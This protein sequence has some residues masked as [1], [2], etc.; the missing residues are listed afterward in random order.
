MEIFVNF[1]MYIEMHAT[2]QYCGLYMALYTAQTFSLIHYILKLFPK[3]KQKVA[4]IKDTELHESF[5]GISK[6]SDL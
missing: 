2:P 6:S 1:M 5:L 4:P 3:D